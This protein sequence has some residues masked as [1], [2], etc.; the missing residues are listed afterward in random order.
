MNA[1]ILSAEEVAAATGQTVEQVKAARARA[2]ARKAEVAVKKAEEKASDKPKPAKISEKE[3][4]TGKE[5]P[6]DR[7][8]QMLHVEKK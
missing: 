7:L 3:T 6:E 4:F 2:E 5:I 8:R 1:K